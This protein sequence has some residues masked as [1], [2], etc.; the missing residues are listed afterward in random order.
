MRDGVRLAVDLH[1]P[2]DLGAGDRIPTILCQ[3]RYHR[4]TRYRPLFAA[5]FALTDPFRAAR[6]RIMRH[7]YAFV[8]VDVRGSGASF[9][10]RRMEWSPEEVADGAEV[11]DWIVRQPWSDGAV[12]VTGISYVGTAAEMLL[13]VR[14]PA[15]KAAHIRY[16]PFDICA[17]IAN[18]G[19]VRNR[20]FL[21]IWSALNRAL[22]GNRV[23][24]LARTALGRL[25]ALPIEGAA[26]V[27][28]DEDGRERAAAVAGH[29]ENYDILETAL[30]IAFRDDRTAAGVQYDAFSPHAFLPELEASGAAVYSVSSYFDGANGLAAVKRFLSVRSPDNRLLLGPWDHGGTQN[31]NPFA[32]SRRSGFDQFGEVL[33]YF[34]RHLKGLAN[35]IEREPPVH[36]FTM[37]EEAWKSAETWPPPG[38]PPTPLYLE[39]GHRLSWTPPAAETGW[40]R[41]RVDPAA[42][43]GPTSRWVSL[44]NVGGTRVGYPDRRTRD[45]RLLVYQSAPLDRAAE[46][47]GHPILTLFLR[48]SAEDGQFFAYLEDVSPGGEV[49]YVTE[50]LCRALHR[51]APPDEPP[52]YRLPEGV[53]YRSLTRAHARPLVPGEITEITFDLMPVSHLFAAGHAIRLAVAGADRDNFEPVPDEPPEIEVLRA[54]AHASRLV[55][56]LRMR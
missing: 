28:G 27:D 30:G 23:S 34:D 21:E 7:G 20:R 10:A 26:P 49:R 9:G 44:A 25:A 1:L 46:V 2:R 43:S 47:T 51:P 32:P 50:G 35:G 39:G 36:Y 56:P 19:G 38:F 40:D 31:P 42:S 55:L 54:G 29:A 45:R 17:D 48:S 24:A 5:L 4:R 3:T 6:G 12:G 33:R 15:V 8:T 41:Y 11:V 37:G 14:H 22:D 52:P 16:A 53:P 18:P 13:T